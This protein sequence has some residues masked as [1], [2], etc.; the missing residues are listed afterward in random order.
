MGLMDVLSGLFQPQQ[1]Q[2]GAAPPPA[3]PLGI[4]GSQ[5]LSPEAMQLLAK[6]GLQ[7]PDQGE[8]K[9]RA[10]ASAL[11]K[12]GQA[13]ATSKQDF[14]PALV[15]AMGDAAVDYTGARQEQESSHRKNAQDLLKQMF[16]L[17]KLD[18]TND[19][20][21]AIADMKNDLFLKKLEETI[22]HNRATEKI[23]GDRVIIMGNNADTA[24]KNA[25]TNARRVAEFGR[26]NIE[27]EQQGRDR[28]AD[29]VAKT[30]A[31]IKKDQATAANTGGKTDSDFFLNSSRV[32]QAKVAKAKALNL[33]KVEFSVTDPDGWQ[34]AKEEFD[35]FSAG[36][37]A[38]L[39]A[40]SSPTKRR[41]LSAT[42]NVEN[43][44]L[45]SAGAP[46]VKPPP[47]VATPPQKAVGTKGTGSSRADPV[48]N[49]TSK[50]EFDSLPSG[51]WF[52]NPKDGKTYRKK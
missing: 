3:A 27:T 28:I 37:D 51:A 17:E 52:V 8:E 44:A 35:K 13:L 45:K 23:G 1:Q 10:I 12:G 2:A 42:E 26:H 11:A 20:R 33:D 46:V 24:A 22:L 7:P 40:T 32:Q 41:A 5:N 36:L 29:E 49:I 18:Q 30:A 9:R 38:E 25:D 43:Q 39:A 31:Q 6:F 50:T 47:T 21:S 14:G 4:P 34:R 15:S 19:A 16:G 48:A